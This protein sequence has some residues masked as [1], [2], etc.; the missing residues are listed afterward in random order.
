MAD[1]GKGDP[2]PR[3]RYMVFGCGSIGYNVIEELLKETTNIIVIDSDEKRVEDLKDQKYQALV[4]DISDPDLFTDLPIPE[5]VFILS[6]NKEANLNAVE[7]TKKT[8]PQAFSI[9]RAVDLFSVDTLVEAGADVVLYPQ[10]VVA[11]SAVHHMKTLTAARSAHR[12]YSIFENWT[13][14][15]GVLTHRNPDPD[16]ISSAMALCAIAQDAAKGQLACR[17]LYEGTVGHQENRAFVNLLDIQMER[18]TPEKLAECNHLA[19]VDSPGPGINNDLHPGTHVD[20]IID[21]HSMEGIERSYKPDFIDIRPESG[22]T[23]SIFAQYLQELDVPI[24]TKIATALYYGI[25]ADTR[26]FRRNVTPNDLYNAAYLLPLSDTDLLDKIMSPSFSQETLEVMGN[27][28][29]TRSIKNGYLFSNVGYIRNRDAIPQ[30]A[31]MLVNLEGVTTA[32]VYGIS[33]AHIIISARNKDIR[34]HIGN[35]LKEAFGDFGDAGGH[36][37][38]AAAQIPLNYFSMVRD[39]EDLLQMI[40]D[41]ILHR[42]TDIVGIDDNGDKNEI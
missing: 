36:G 37:T 38:M 24:D 26:E 34:V 33:D 4:R 17:I 16:S 8:H 28:I 11:R 23:A 39:K 22:A 15:L 14:T 35:V 6:S 12:L 29:S 25:R 40:I 9:A 5:I 32:L 2:K 30:A 21:H 10:Q 13:G 27:A 19:L 20:I 3:V 41:P 18:M 1:G 7:Q 42:F 31:D